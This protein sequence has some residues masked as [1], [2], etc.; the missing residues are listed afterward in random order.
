MP[1]MR[2]WSMS[3]IQSDLNLSGVSFLISNK[4]SK[5]DSGWETFQ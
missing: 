4:R 2:V 1:E 5:S 3:L